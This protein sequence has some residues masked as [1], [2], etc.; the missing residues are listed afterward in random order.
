MPERAQVTRESKGNLLQPSLA[1]QASA[2]Q[3]CPAEA[4]SAKADSGPS[5]PKRLREGGPSAPAPRPFPAHLQP[6]PQFLIVGDVHTAL[7][8]LDARVPERQLDDAKADAVPGFEFIRLPHHV[9]HSGD[10]LHRRD[11]D[12]TAIPANGPL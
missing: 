2:R 6:S 7:G 9:R 3:A 8:L 1:L 4:R 10:C 5:A 11:T 12:D